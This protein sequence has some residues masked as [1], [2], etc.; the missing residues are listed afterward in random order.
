MGL[1]H[2]SAGLVLKPLAPKVPLW[3]LLVVSEGIDILFF[4]FSF[5]GIEK[6]SV[7][8]TS[9]ERGVETIT[10]GVLYWSHGLFMATV[11]SGIAALITYLVIKKT[12]PALVV[13]LVF[14]SHWLLDFL[15]HN[16]SL[17]VFFEGSPNVGL[18]M[19]GSGTGLIISGIL[20]LVLLVGGLIIFVRWRNAQSNRKTI[21]M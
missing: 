1:G 18:G 11:W 21:N 4:L 13:G 9:M 5:L 14:F 16:R 8:R 7:T 12:K 10:P 15:V 19:W 20:E 17:P 3:I 6:Q 2:L